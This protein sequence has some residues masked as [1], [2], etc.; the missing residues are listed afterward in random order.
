MAGGGFD[1][2]FDVGFDIGTDESRRTT[3]HRNPGCW[4]RPPNVQCN[5]EGNTEGWV[6]L[7]VN[8]QPQEA[9]TWRK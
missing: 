7:T 8:M 1:V 6:P 4:T 2:G 9:Q 3:W 5:T